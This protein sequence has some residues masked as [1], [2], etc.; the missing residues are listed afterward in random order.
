MG[1]DVNISTRLLQALTDAGLPV[2]SV[3]IPDQLNRATW[4]A[5]YTRTLTAG[6]RTTEQAIGAVIPIIDP[7]DAI[8]SAAVAL[9]ATVN[10]TDA[11]LLT[12]AQSRNLILLLAAKEGWIAFDGVKYTI[13]VH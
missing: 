13:N 6:E 4:S 3:S 9:A 7:Q 2:I 11:T 8:Y 12:L 5:Q 1:G 10:G